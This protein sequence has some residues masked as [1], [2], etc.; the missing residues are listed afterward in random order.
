MT[1][2][3]MATLQSSEALYDFARNALLTDR[4]AY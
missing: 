4:L 3:E 2:L 1:A